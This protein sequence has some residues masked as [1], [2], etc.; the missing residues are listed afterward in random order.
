[1]ITLRGWAPGA[2][3]PPGLQ[4]EA[5]APPVAARVPEGVAV[6]VVVPTTAAWCEAV[7]GE[8]VHSHTLPIVSTSPNSL[9]G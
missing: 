2:A 5:G 9:A 7:A 3:E 1:M 4:H 6:V 8:S